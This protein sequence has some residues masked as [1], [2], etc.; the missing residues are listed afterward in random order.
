[1]SAPTEKQLDYI[2]KLAN[3]LT[4]ERV[5]YL[6][7]SSVVAAP[8]TSAEASGLIGDLQEAIEA[9]EKRQAESPVTI[10]ARITFDYVRKTGEHARVTATVTG[11]RW[12]WLKVAAIYTA[13]EDEQTGAWKKQGTW[14]VLA[15]MTNIQPYAG[16]PEALEAE[17]KRLRARIAEIDAILARPGTP[18]ETEQQ[19]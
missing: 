4:G 17:R 11:Y 3:Q 15:R 13:D 1:M 12:E 9:E 8:K 18:A 5:R 19:R 10:G 7:Q 14:L 6:S 16:Y 2:L